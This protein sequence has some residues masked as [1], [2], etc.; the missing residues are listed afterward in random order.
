MR[1]RQVEVRPDGEGY[2]GDHREEEQHAGQRPAAGADG[3]FYVAEVEGEHSY[4]PPCGEGASSLGEASGNLPHLQH[5][6]ALHPER[7]MRCGDDDAAAAEM[8]RH[9]RREF[10]LRRCIE[11]GGRFVEQPD[12]AAADQEFC[13]RR[14]PALAGGE[15]AVGQMADRAEADRPQR[16]LHREIGAA[17]KVPPEAQILGHRQRRLH[18][19]QMAEIMAGRSDGRIRFAAAFDEHLAR[20]L[21]QQAGNHPEQ[22]RFTGAVRSGDDQ[23]VAFA[24]RKIHP[25]KHRLPAALAAQIFGDQPHCSPVAESVIGAPSRRSKIGNSV[26]RTIPGISLYPGQPRQRS[27]WE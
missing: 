21:R 3:E 1:D 9:Q 5:R 27:V 23:A 11:P 8:R 7:Q 19:V 2:G 12:R 13:D 10:C 14:P 18:R 22:R 17:A 20:R 4:P 25:G 6:R 24:E 15:V 16:L 26:S